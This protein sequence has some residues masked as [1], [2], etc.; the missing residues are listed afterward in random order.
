MYKPPAYCSAPSP[1]AFT[2]DS[3]LSSS[4]IE[5]FYSV[6][7]HS[8]LLNVNINN[9]SGKMVNCMTADVGIV[10]EGSGDTSELKVC[11]EGGL[12]CWCVDK[13]GRVIASTLTHLSVVSDSFP[14]DC[15]LVEQSLHLLGGVGK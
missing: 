7:S 11:A 10:L 4:Q 3:S 15:D 6:N 13:L 5:A 14:Y 8:C 1:S 2:L 12:S 9:Y